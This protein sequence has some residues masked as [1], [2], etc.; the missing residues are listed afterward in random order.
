V[1][2]EQ[3]AGKLGVRVARAVGLVRLEHQAVS[4]L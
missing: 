3:Q 1:E 4:R 2:D